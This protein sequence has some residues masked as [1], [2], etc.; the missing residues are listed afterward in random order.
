MERLLNRGQGR[1]DDNTEAI[2]KRFETFQQKNLPV[3][4]YY[5]QFNKVRRID[6]NR[7]SIEIYEDT[8]RAMLPQIT[9]MIGPKASG[10]T[11]LGTA[12]CK[13]TNMKL[14]NYNAFVDEQG[15]ADCN[16]EEKTQALIASLS[17][18]VMPRVLLEDFPQ[19]EFQAKFF[20]KNCTPPSRVFALECSKDVCQER[21]TIMAQTDNSYQPSAILSKRIKQ[22]NENSQRLVPYLKSTTNFKSIN[23]EMNFDSAFNQ[24][25]S[26]VEPTILLVR[27]GGNPDSYEK[28]T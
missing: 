19:T 4:A 15:L 20:N 10:K 14:I 21:M 16:E 22:Y 28:R 11:T 1:S 17:K 12:L 26:A 6:A 7:D 23:S 27:P 9:C 8:R 3:V 13:R 25:C 24:L 18:E 2:E 5:E